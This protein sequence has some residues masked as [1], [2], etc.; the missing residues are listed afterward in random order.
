MR[1]RWVCKMY[2]R[3]VSRDVDLL[4]E[5]SYQI[6][7]ARRRVAVDQF[8]SLEFK[9]DQSWLAREINRKLPRREKRLNEPART[10][11]VGKMPRRN[12]GNASIFHV[13]VAQFVGEQQCGRII[14]GGPGGR[15]ND[16]SQR[17]YMGI[18]HE[19]F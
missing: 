13:K 14:E 3:L 9:A 11:F 7:A 2:R 12:N 16:I 10:F 6:G 8:D 18:A 15:F 17:L 19:E 4:R 5:R 1:I